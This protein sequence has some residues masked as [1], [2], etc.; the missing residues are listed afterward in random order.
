MFG[1]TVTAKIIDDSIY[2]IDN[3][4]TDDEKNMYLAEKFVFGKIPLKPPTKEIK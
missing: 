2:S 4:L 1:V 3:Q